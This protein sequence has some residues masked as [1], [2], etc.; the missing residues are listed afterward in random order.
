M[1]KRIFFVLAL[2]V[3]FGGGVFDQNNWI[4]AEINVLGSGARYE[5]VINPYLTVGANFYYEFWPVPMQ[6]GSA[7]MFGG[8]VSARWYPTGRKFFLELDLGGMSYDGGRYERVEYYDGYQTQY[9]DEWV[10]YNFGGFTLTPG[11]GWTVDVGKIGG[12]FISPGLKV[13][14]I[15]AGEN[16]GDNEHIQNYQNYDGGTIFTPVLYF[17]MGFAF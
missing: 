3:L 6:Y 15:F 14:L 17:A 13:P 7:S 4:S 8:G 11:L 5:R 12:F 1:K 16:T 10:N 2:M 9:R